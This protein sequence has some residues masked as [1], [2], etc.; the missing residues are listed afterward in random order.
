VLEVREEVRQRVESTINRLDRSPPT[1]R[2]VF[3]VLAGL[4]SL[5]LL[6]VPV[7]V[8]R[9]LWR[10]QPFAELP[11]GGPW[12]VLM[13]I[14]FWVVIVWVALAGRVPKLLLQ[15]LRHGQ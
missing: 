1:A 15:L 9:H 14:V 13:L 6:I 8:F 10:G 3:R 2:P 4:L 7:E 11:F 5:G 12:Q